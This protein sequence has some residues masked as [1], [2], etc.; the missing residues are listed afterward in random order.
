MYGIGI[1]QD[2]KKKSLDFLTR[3]TDA[4]TYSEAP[5]DSSGLWFP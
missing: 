2:L 5:S 3:G 4:C 1:F